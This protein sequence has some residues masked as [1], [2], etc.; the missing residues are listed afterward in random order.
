[1]GRVLKNTYPSLRKYVMARS[2]AKH[3]IGYKKPNLLKRIFCVPQFM[4]MFSRPSVARHKQ[5]FERNTCRCI[6]QNISGNL[7]GNAPIGKIIKFDN[8]DKF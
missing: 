2:W 7:L 4:D 5:F 3:I 6:K 8:R 1:M